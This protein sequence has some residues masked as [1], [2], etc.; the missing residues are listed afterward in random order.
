M[1]QAYPVIITK[2]KDFFV[3]SS[4]I[5]K[6]ERGRIFGRGNRNGNETQ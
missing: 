1:K 3:A 5:L 6:R 2:D 4:P